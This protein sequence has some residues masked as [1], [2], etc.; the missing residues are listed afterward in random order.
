MWIFINKMMHVFLN[1]KK[2]DFYPLPDFRILVGQ[3]LANIT[4]TAI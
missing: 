4:K 1:G 2:E 3:S